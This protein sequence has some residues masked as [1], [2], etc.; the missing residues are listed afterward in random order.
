MKKRLIASVTCLC[1]LLV[2]LMSSTLAW[3]TDTEMSHNTMTVGNVEIE[4]IEQYRE[5]RVLQLWTDNY[6]PAMNPVVPEGLAPELAK[7]PFNINGKPYDL[8]NEGQLVIDKIVT[9]ENVGSDPAWVR[10]VFAFE[11]TKTVTEDGNGNEIITW[12]N[13]LGNEVFINEN[14]NQK[15]TFPTVKDENGEDV[16]V[17]VYR[18]VVQENGKDKFVYSDKEIS[19]PNLDA[20]F[21]IGETTYEKALEKKGDITVPSLLQV[22][23]DQNEDGSTF[24]TSVN[25]E[26]EILVLSQA[27]QFAGFENYGA[28]TSLNHAFGVVNAA[29]AAK[30]LGGGEYESIPLASVTDLGAQRETATINGWGSSA[31]QKVLNLPFVLQFEPN[32]TLEEA[33]ASP[34]RYWHADYVVKADRDVPA[35]S[36]ALAGYYQVFCDAINEGNWVALTADSIIPAGTEIRLVDVLGGG[37]GSGNGSIKVTY[38]DICQYGNDGTGF[39]CSAVDLTGE[40]ADTTLTVELRMYANESDPTNSSYNGGTETGE[41]LVLGTYTYTFEEQIGIRD[42]ASL[43]TALAAGEKNIIISDSITLTES[44]GA[45]DVTFV[46]VGENAGINFNGHNIGGSGTITYKNLNLTT[47]ALPHTPENGERYGWHGG[48]DYLGHSVA[49]YE[50]CTITGVFTTYSPVV[51]VTDCTFD[52]YVQDGEEYYNIFMYAACELTATRCTFTYGDRAIKAFSEG[53]NQYKLTLKDCEFVADEALTLNK[54]LIMV[55]NGN[56]TL[57][58]TNNTIAT[59]LQTLA[60]Y[61][62]EGS[63]TVT[64]Q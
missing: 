33:N 52:Y 21:V 46:G 26:Y 2:M 34:Y 9:V 37:D 64:V 29:N 17:I 48:I 25:G 11:L 30:W 62:T 41:Y 59:E 51:N 1:L 50:N 6:K 42:M 3:F 36:V 18:Y 47:V 13:P 35:N 55:S 24:R 8:F 15:I 49:N 16:N 57:S 60:L 20:A 58:V 27:M 28:N 10:T 31:E 43:K 7:S 45:T 5:D 14:P 44:L 32:E 63:A 56:M 53:F 39:L 23:L 19:A 12:N 54:A 40:N 61:K 22:Y 4:Q 38:K